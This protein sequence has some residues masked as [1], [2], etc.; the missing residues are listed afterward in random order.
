MDVEILTRGSQETL[1][2]AG[3]AAALV[4]RLADLTGEDPSTALRTALQ[5]CLEKEVDIRERYT[6]VMKIAEEIRQGMTEPLSSTDHNDLY[7]EDGL[8]K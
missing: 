4:R 5:K 3:D 8:P 2:L 6:R 7:G 1:Q